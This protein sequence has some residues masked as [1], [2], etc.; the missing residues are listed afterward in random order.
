MSAVNIKE[1]YTN[2]LSLAVFPGLLEDSVISALCDFLCTEDN[3]DDRVSEYSNFV[4][5]V[6]SCGNSFA[7]HLQN[8]VNDDENVY[9]RTISAGKTPSKALENAVTAELGILQS[10]S[11]ITPEMLKEVIDY[12][13]YLGSKSILL[14]F[15]GF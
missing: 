7:C 5:K 1:I 3:V 2:L 8:L 9:I 15:I 10:V 13:G 6:F 11:E 14:C 12:H 4:S